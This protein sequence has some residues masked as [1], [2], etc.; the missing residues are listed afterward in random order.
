MPDLRARA[1]THMYRTEPR[2]FFRLAFR[3]LHPGV[4]Y[5]HNWSID[6]LGEALARCARGETR[7]LI[8]N[9]PPRSLKSLCSSVAFPAWLLGVRP[10]CQIMCVAGHRGLAEDQ[11]ELALRLM[12]DKRYRSLFPHV[13]IGES[14]GR[15]ALPQGGYRLG[16][17]PSAAITGRG[18]DVVIIDDPQS[19]SNAEDAGA[20]RDVRRWYDRNVYPRLNDKKTGVVIVVMQ[21]LAHDDLTA[22]L[23]AQGGWD[24][25]SLPAI[26][27]ADEH[28]PASLGGGLA[29]CA[30]EALHPD[31][32]DRDALREALIRMGAKAFMAQY[33]QKPYGPGEGEGHGG[34]FHLVRE[35]PEHR[36]MYS[37][38][39]FLQVDQEQFVLQELFGEETTAHPG[40]PPPMTEE[41]WRHRAQS[42]RRG[43]PSPDR[44]IKLSDTARGTPADLSA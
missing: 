3:L 29:R 34:A 4:A 41:A 5:E 24:V 18:A 2:M 36:T 40:P 22:H 9:M 13:R 33:Q 15:L 30:G 12:T 7:R 44:W 1:I 16:L 21:R 17:T 43:E 28:L 32:E 37:P 35:D 23:V 27:E 14:H 26:A 38:V 20:T 39:M 8:V 6:V 11:H 25:I 10:D 42:L 31:R 19:P